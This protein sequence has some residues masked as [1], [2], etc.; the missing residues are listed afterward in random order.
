MKTICKSY[1]A[2]LFIG[3]GAYAYMVCTGYSNTL[4]YKA[5]GA[6]LFSMGLLSVCAEGMILVTGQFSKLYD[7]SWSL[8]QI[9]LIFVANLIGIATIFGLYELGDTTLFPDPIRQAGA[10]IAAAR[11][12]SL[13][14]QH[15]LRG[16]FCGICIEA[17]CANYCNDK[18]SW[19]VI[20]PVMMFILIGGEHCI[21]DAAYYL[22]APGWEWRHLLQIFEVFC[23]NLIGA[24]VVVFASANREFHF[25]L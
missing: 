2:G 25:H 7:G 4:G 15:I 22:F 23:G 12:S 11:D 17:A 6:F 21:A 20:L 24:I 5:L 13:W 1:L 8:R 10:T 19:G 16:I 14:Y 9:F 3:L 18:S